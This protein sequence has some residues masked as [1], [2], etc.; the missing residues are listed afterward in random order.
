[1]T[2]K[3]VAKISGIVI[4]IIYALIGFFLTSAFFAIKLHITNDPG[5]VDFNDRYFQ[6]VSQKEIYQNKNLK[7]TTQNNDAIIYYKIMVLNEYFPKNAKLILDAFNKSKNFIMAERMFDALNL[8]LKDNK[9][10]QEK[11]D[12]AK[13]ISK[14]MKGNRCDSN[15]YKWMNMDEWSV[16]KQAV[17]KDTNTIDSIAGITNVCSRLI[18]SVLVGEQIRLFD[19][20]KEGYKKWVAPL[21][22]LAN[23]TKISW[24]ITGIKEFTAIDIERYLKD[25][26]SDYYIGE[27]YEH[28]LDFKTENIEDERYKRLIDNKNHKYAYLYAAIF[29]K[30][31][32]HQWNKAGFDISN[33]VEILATLYNVGFI[34]SV[35]KADP[36]VGGSHIKIKGKTYTFGSLAYEFF[37]SGELI[38]E[39]PFPKG[40]KLFKD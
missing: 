32:M 18:A 38:D 35:P 14:N 37:Y 20:T 30:Q 31:V 22:I 5:A 33:R 1:M 21:K 24:G 36:K 2:F 3:K 25:K 7:D 10:I 23:E 11:F 34:S 16:F 12:Y 6:E 28:L 40:S 39:F 26:K 9:D 27:K 13:I 4:V 19:S 29:L 17:V 8:Y 15:I